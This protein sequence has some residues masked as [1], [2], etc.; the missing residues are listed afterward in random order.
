MAEVL[1]GSSGAEVGPERYQ[2]VVDGVAL[3]DG[4]AYFASR[5]SLLGQ[6]PGEVIAAAFGVFSAAVVVP[7]VRL[8][9]TRT[10]A[11][12]IRAARAD[13]NVEPARRIVATIAAGEKTPF[14]HAQR[15]VLA[16]LARLDEAQLAINKTTAAPDDA[17]TITLGDV[18]CYLPLAGMVDLEQEQE[19]L[20]KEFENLTQQIERVSNLLSGPFAEKAPPAVV[21]KERDKLARLEASRDE[22]A[23]R[24]GNN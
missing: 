12:T 7:S 23:Q 4:P 20:R 19:R 15:Q 16:F 8:A 21:Q 17:L 9:W 1:T 11:A 10:D 18:S 24:L 13:N 6:V 2:Q 22:I 5:G 3:P 14:Y